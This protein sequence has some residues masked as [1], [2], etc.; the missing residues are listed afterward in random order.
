MDLASAYPNS[1]ISTGAMLAI[2]L[3]MAGSLAFWLVMVF[4]A[5]RQRRNSS[6]RLAAGPAAE[7]AGPVPAGPDETAEDERS[8]AGHRDGTR[9]IQPVGW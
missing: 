7:L 8:G 2:A 9:R 3:V 6:A 4:V 5:D 1:A